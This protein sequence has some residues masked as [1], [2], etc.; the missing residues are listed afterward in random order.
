MN[1]LN[2]NQCH[3]NFAIGAAERG[4]SWEHLNFNASLLKTIHILIVKR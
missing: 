4:L 2:L 1:D 3:L